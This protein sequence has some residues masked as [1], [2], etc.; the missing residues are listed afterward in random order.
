M[1]NSSEVRII[2]SFF[3]LQLFIHLKLSTNISRC[4][5]LSKPTLLFIPDNGTARDEPKESPFVSSTT[6]HTT[7]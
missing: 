1:Y 4:R 7:G 5:N 6:W 2:T 3:T